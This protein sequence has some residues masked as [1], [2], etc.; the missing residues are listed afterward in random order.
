[1]SKKIKIMKAWN[2]VRFYFTFLL[3]A[4]YFTISFL[5][6]F[7]NA[8]I[9]FIPKGR[10]IIGLFLFVFGVV[11]FY[12]AY[13]RYKQKQLSIQFLKEKKTLQNEKQ[14]ATNLNHIGT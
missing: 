8:W 6:L 5:F 10:V 13:R 14:S 4:F 2:S 1:M 3:L 9:G 7:T 12:V 11:R